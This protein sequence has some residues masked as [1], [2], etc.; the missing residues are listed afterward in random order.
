LHAYVIRRI[1]QMIPLIIGVTII[2][3]GI[4]YLAPGDPIDVLATRTATPEQ[5]AHLRTVYGLDQPVYVQYWKWFS[6]LIVG[7]FGRSF[8]EG[9]PVMDMILER[10]PNTLYLNAVVALIIYAAAIPIGIVSALRQY[11]WFDN[12]VTSAAFFGLALPNFWF[13]LLLIYY[14][15]MKVDLIPIAGIATYGFTVEKVGWVAVLL[16]R[17]KYLIL[18]TIVLSTPG[19]AAVSRYMRS[20]MLE[21][22][23]QDYIRTAKAKGLSGRVVLYKHALRNAL[24]PIVTLIGFELPILF[25][26]SVIVETIFSWPG[27]GLLSIRAIFQRDYMVVMAFNVIGAALV[28]TGNFI[29]DLLYAVVDPRIKY[30]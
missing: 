26:G 27:L 25:S 30:D 10:L 11:T 5:I 13:G 29:A 8:V 22:I 7:D 20:S 2:S 19:I 17:L 18:P 14:V 21:V 15:A 4:M 3:F 23:R 1:L 28:L 6:K 24:L 9:R 16:D 12:M